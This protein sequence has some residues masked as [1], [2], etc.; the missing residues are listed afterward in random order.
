MQFLSWALY[1]LVPLFYHQARPITVV[2][3]HIGIVIPKPV[4]NKY[5][6]P[7]SEKLA[8]IDFFFSIHCQISIP[9]KA[10]STKATN[11][12]VYC[13]IYKVPIYFLQRPSMLPVAII[14]DFVSSF[15]Q[16]AVRYGLTGCHAEMAERQ[17]VRS[18]GVT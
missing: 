12:I 11:K 5:C 10:S 1:Q 3:R 14:I 13:M 8:P 9:I 6:V 17:Q 7:D 4:N 15:R 16:H 18:G 2:N